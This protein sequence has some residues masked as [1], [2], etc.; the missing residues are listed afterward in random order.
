[1]MKTLTVLLFLCC[2]HN[3][4]SQV[5][6]FISMD[7]LFPAPDKE[8]PKKKDL[9][10]SVRGFVTPDSIIFEIQVKDDKLVLGKDQATSDHVEVWFGFHECDFSDFIVANTRDKNASRIFRNSV[11]PGDNA[12]LERFLKLGDYPASGKIQNSATLEWLPA[13]VPRPEELKKESVFYG[14]SSFACFPDNRSPLQMNRDKY[15]YIEDQLFPFD[16][17]SGALQSKTEKTSEGYSMRIALHNSCLLFGEPASM[18][19]FRFAV[20]VH[21]VDR[22]DGQVTQLISTAKNNY[23]ARPFYFNKASFP[24]PLNIHLDQVPDEL[25]RKMGLRFSMVRSGGTWKP[26]YYSNGSIIYAPEM[27]SDAGFVEYEFYPAKISYLESGRD[28]EV[29][30][31]RLDIEFDDISAFYQHEVY[32]TIGDSVALSSKEFRFLN[33]EPGDFIN[34]IFKLKDGSAA[35]VLYDYEP[36]DPFGWGEYGMTA[37]EFVYIQ[38]LDKNSGYPIFSV[39][40]RIEATGNVTVGDP[41]ITRLEHVKSVK[42]RWLKFG[43]TFEMQVDSDSPDFKRNLQFQIGADNKIT[44][45]R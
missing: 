23:Y 11:E 44:L 18:K 37:D 16:N 36:V 2:I 24:F 3:L 1:M 43:E 27:M 7:E 10:A 14:I 17:L 20:Q 6:S 26:Y 19:E 45:I 8:V 39:G 41:L 31:S 15:K 28:A 42:Y 13:D 40:Q 35:A 12:D 25:I 21:D 22:K 29:S 34:S 30:W 4:Q 5:H 38:K 33:E 32:F 9:S